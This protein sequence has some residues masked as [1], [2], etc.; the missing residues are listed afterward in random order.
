MSG[1]LLSE[2]PGVAPGDQGEVVWCSMYCRNMQLKFLWRNFQIST[3]GF[4]K[5]GVKRILS[6]FLFSSLS[7]FLLFLDGRGNILN[8][9]SQTLCPKPLLCENCH[10]QSK[11]GGWPQWT[12]LSPARHPEARSGQ[13]TTGWPHELPG[14]EPCTK[15]WAPT[16]HFAP[17]P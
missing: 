6:P 12:E 14:R 7:P 3:Q 15:S 1:F 17:K 8:Q 10:P 9:K 5:T 11:V 16:V 13:E 4:P 2:F